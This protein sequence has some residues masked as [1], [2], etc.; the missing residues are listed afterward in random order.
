MD[1]DVADQYRSAL[2]DLSVAGVKLVSVSWPTEQEQ[3]DIKA[4]FAGMVP[5]YLLATLG[6]RRFQDHSHEIDPV[7]V[8]RLEG[9]LAMPATEFI[10][11]KRIQEKLASAARD[12]MQGLDGIIGPTVPLTP[13]P[14][15]EVNE[16]VLNASDFVARSLS[17]T[18]AANVYD[19]CAMTIPLSRLPGSMP[20]GLQIT[21]SAN[22]EAKMLSLAMAL[23]H[24]VS[25]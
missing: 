11:L 12:R 19:M 13:R 7:A 23:S 18:R 16:N 1:D 24:L 25:N 10:R 14:V 3:R 22:N 9:A 21:C 17:Y 6:H 8:K 5:A 4:I 15:C 2:Q 20:V